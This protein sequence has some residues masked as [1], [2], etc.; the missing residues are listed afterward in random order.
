ML[1]MLLRTVLVCCMIVSFSAKVHQTQPEKGLEVG[2]L[3]DVHSAVNLTNERGKNYESLRFQFNSASHING[4]WC[5]RMYEG[6]TSW[7]DN[8]W[9]T[10]YDIDLS[11]RWK[12]ADRCNSD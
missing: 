8:Y 1:P 7:Q 11:W 4:W 9:C 6:T 12:S 3:I 5:V 2:K 10:N